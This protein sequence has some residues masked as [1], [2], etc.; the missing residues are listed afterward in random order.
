MIATTYSQADVE[1][2]FAEAEATAD[3]RGVEYRDLYMLAYLRGR[4]GI[5][6]R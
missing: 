4:F 2:F 3:E 1:R 5:E 6:A